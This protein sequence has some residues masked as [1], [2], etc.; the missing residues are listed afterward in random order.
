MG[1]TKRDCMP[2][3]I[4]PGVQ[5]VGGS[6]PGGEGFETA[7]PWRYTW[8]GDQEEI[9]SGL[10]RN[11]I[12]GTVGYVVSLASLRFM[13]ICSAYSVSAPTQLLAQ[14]YLAWHISSPYPPPL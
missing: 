1:V 13:A 2:W 5:E 12:M 14:G 4:A 7:W 10:R 6:R 3:V 9:R 8:Q 11:K